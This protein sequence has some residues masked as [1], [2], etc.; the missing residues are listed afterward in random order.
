ME[1]IKNIGLITSILMLSFLSKIQSQNSLSIQQCYE[2]ATKNYPLVKQL[3]LIEKTKE[4]SIDNASKGYLPQINFA[5]QATYQSEVTKIP[6]A[7]PNTTIKDL[8]KDQYKIYGEIN[9]SL[10][11]AYVIKQQKELIKTNTSSETEKINVELYKLKERINQL[12]FGILLI[13]DQIKQTELLK[14]DIE[15]GI[16]KIEAAIANGIAL[17]SNLDLLSA[18]LLKATQRNTEL[19]YNRKGFTDMLS[20]F[21]NQSLNETTSFSHPSIQAITNNINRPELKLFEAQK[22]TIAIQNKLILAKNLPRLSLFFQ[23]GYGRPTLNFLSNDFG[24]Y[25]IGGARFNWNISGFYT[26]SKEKKIVGINQNMLDIQKDVFLFN[27]NL[28]LKQQNSEISKLTDLIKTD[29]QII[30]LREN[31]KITANNQLENG[32]ITT[33]DYLNYVN[34]ENQAKQNLILHTTQLLL[35]QYNYQTTSGI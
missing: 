9:Q 11:D 7:L 2:L 30:K 23:G 3:E 19:N 22:N 15:S 10:T 24:T 25:Y 18:E 33:I 28:T 27:T 17:K 29:N 1:K 26:Y 5:G 16:K 8:S 14:K 21:I 12:F 31:V 13:D 6:F 4:Y 35:A 20:V 32:T 34:A